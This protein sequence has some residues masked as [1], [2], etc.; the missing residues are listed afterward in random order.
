M[1]TIDIE[2]VQQML[3]KKITIGHTKCLSKNIQNRLWCLG[4]P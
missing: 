2:S 4:T 3:Q 1:V